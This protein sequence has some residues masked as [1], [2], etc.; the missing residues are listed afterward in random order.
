MEWLVSEAEPG[1]RL[2]KLERFAVGV[3]ARFGAEQGGNVESF[4]IRQLYAAFFAGNFGVMS[5]EH[6][7]AG[8]ART[9]GHFTW[10][11]GQALQMQALQKFDGRTGHGEAPGKRDKPTEICTHL[12]TFEILAANPLVAVRGVLRSGSDTD[13]ETVTGT[14]ER[15]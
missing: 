14:L 13:P 2:E 15:I 1:L 6:Q 3:E 12:Y 4:A 5:P 11:Y 10:N 7:G 9:P 8:L